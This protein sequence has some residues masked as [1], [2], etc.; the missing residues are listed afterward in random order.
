MHTDSLLFL[1]FNT[2]VDLCGIKKGNKITMC[3]PQCRDLRLRYD[4]FL[5]KEAVND[6]T[7]AC[8]ICLADIFEITVMWIY[9]GFVPVSNLFTEFRQKLL[10]I[11]FF[12]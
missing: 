5:Y 8:V 11:T 12:G 6:C 4:M 9:F 10:H 1:T 2:H 7:N 3:L